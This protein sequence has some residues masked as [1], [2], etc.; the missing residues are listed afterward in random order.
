MAVT[1]IHPINATLSKAIDYI[2]NED[3]TD[4]GM[5]VSTLGCTTDGIKASK[6]FDDIRK[7]GTGRTTILAQHLVQSF[8]PGEITAEQAHQIGLELCE[9]LLGNQY[10]YVIATH[11]DK[12]H[13]HNHIIFN[14]VDFVNYRSFEYQQNRGGKIFEKIQKISD[15]L[16]NEHGLEV[17][18]NPELGRGMSHYEWEMDKQGKSWKTQLRN[19]IDKTIMESDSFDDFLDKLRAKDIEVVYRPENTVKIKFR[20]PGQQRFAR[21]GGGTRRLGW[22]YDAPQI[23]RRIEQCYL[24]RTGQ[25]Q[26]P[27]KSKLIDTSQE[28]FQQSKGLER[29]AEIRNMQEASKLLNILTEHNL[30]SQ[31]EL[32]D[33]AL[34][35]YGE[36]VEIVN[37][38]SGLQRKI[39]SIRDTIKTLKRYLKYKTFD[40]EYKKA[41]FKNKYA[42]DHEKELRQYDSARQEL[43]EKFPNKK[44]PKIETLYA[45]QSSLINQ[46]NSLNKE[47]KKILAE[48]EQLDYARETI[49]EYLEKSDNTKSKKKELN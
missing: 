42:K 18:K 37:R 43:L 33:K 15:K 25:R 16:C 9:K 21:G 17:I 31:K 47:Y 26:T 2:L 10:Q 12:G 40:E 4:N 35:R 19:E 36:R 29:W 20:M 49:R 5:L 22:Y 27:R 39:E 7:Q 45:E 3:K 48:F 23:K 34:E 11:I 14:E 6:A 28:K 8:K 38:L 41:T 44:L 32:E 24:L 30:N 13:I 46:R 1:S